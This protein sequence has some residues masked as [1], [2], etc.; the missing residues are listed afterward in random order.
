M[1]A[2]IP[3]YQCHT[4]TFTSGLSK[5]TKDH[6][7]VGSVIETIMKEIIFEGILQLYDY[8]KKRK[9]LE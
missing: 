6:A 8:R 4:D 7:D 2:Y 9:Y 3:L 1:C 5:S